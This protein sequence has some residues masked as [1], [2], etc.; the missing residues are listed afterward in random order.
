LYPFDKDGTEAEKWWRLFD[1]LNP[2]IREAN[3]E[4]FIPGPFWEN[5]V[6]HNTYNKIFS[7]AMKRAEE[8]RERRTQ[9]LASDI[10]ALLNRQTDVE[11]QEIRQVVIDILHPGTG[12]TNSSESPSSVETMEPES[13]S[14]HYSGGR[15]VHTPSTTTGYPA[16]DFANAWQSS[17][18]SGITSQR[19]RP[20]KFLYCVITSRDSS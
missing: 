14:F 12:N 9:S 5:R 2:G 13:D 11:R 3:P 17:S 18:A 20:Y 10:Q 1:K 4:A 8:I 6:A 16:N 7:E 15:K 19:A